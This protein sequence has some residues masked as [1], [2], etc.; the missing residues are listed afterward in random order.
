M[1]QENNN[2]TMKFYVNIIESPSDRDIYFGK[3]EGSLIQQVVNLNGIPCSVRYAISKDAFIFA[4]THD[5]P[6][7]IKSYNDRA[8]VLH[9]STHGFPQGIQLSNGDQITWKELREILT[10]LSEALQGNL[11]ICMSCCS[12]ISACQMA[13]NVD[14]TE[15]PFFAV[16]GHPKE[17]TWPDTAVAYAT[18]YHLIAKGHQIDEAVKAMQI[19]SGDAGFQIMTAKRAKQAYIEVLE[20]MKDENI[21]A[22]LENQLQLQPP[23]P[24]AKT[25]VP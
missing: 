21:P 4:L 9:I 7:V 10:P 20:E 17:P 1:T 14:D 25:F 16:I 15:E 11:L 2:E 18:F 5:L 24:L 19:A 12:G 6:Q 8:P 13:M 23:S 3:S 22:T